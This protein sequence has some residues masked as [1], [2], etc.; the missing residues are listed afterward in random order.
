MRNGDSRRRSSKADHLFPA[1]LLALE[2]FPQR[3]RGRIGDLPSG[4][5]TEALPQEAE[6][7]AETRPGQAFQDR[8]D[9]VVPLLS[10]E[11]VGDGNRGQVLEVDLEEKVGRVV[12]LPPLDRIP[13]TPERARDG[14]R[15]VLEGDSAHEGYPGKLI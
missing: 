15:L 6:P 11:V 8:V 5:E 9:P 1:A 4:E 2:D 7:L 12:S 3:A 10:G 14:K 13:V